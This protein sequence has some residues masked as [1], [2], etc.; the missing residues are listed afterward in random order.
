[1]TSAGAQDRD[2]PTPSHRDGR[3]KKQ[4]TETST[5]QKPAL[6]HRDGLGAGEGVPPEAVHVPSA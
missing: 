5:A 6:P 1:M 3:Q 4:E 2:S